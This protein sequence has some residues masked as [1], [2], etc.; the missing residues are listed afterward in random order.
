MAGQGKN[1]AWTG[2]GDGHRKGGGRFGYGGH[3]PFQ[4]V[5]DKEGFVQREIRYAYDL[6]L[7]KP[8]D[9]IFLIPLRLDDCPVPRKL[10]TIHW[11]D[12]FGTQRQDAYADL[13]EALQLRYDQKLKL[14]EQAEEH[15]RLEK[16]ARREAEELA[17]RLAVEKSAHKRVEQE[18]HAKEE[19]KYSPPAL[20]KRTSI[21]EL[22]PASFRRINLY[23]V[24]IGCVFFMFLCIIFGFNYLGKILSAGDTLG[25]AP[26]ATQTQKIN[27]PVTAD[28]NIVSNFL[29]ATKTAIVIPSP[30][31][32]TGSTMI[33][34]KDGMTMVYVPAGEFTMGDD[35][36]WDEKPAHTVYLDAFWIDQTEVTNK[37]Y[38]KCVDAGKC[39]PPISTHTPTDYFNN[40]RYVNH[41][42]VY[43]DWDMAKTYC[44]W[45]GR[46]LPTEPQWEKAAR[47]TD[48][49][50]YPWGDDLPNKNLLN[51]DH[52]VG[53]TTEVGNYQ[54]GKSYYG[55]YD[56]AGNVSEWTADWY[57]VYPG[58]DPNS[59]I[60]G[61]GQTRR[62]LRGGS[63]FDI[64]IETTDRSSDEPTSSNFDIGFRCARSE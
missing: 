41:P 11:V 35:N 59:S 20:A 18:A 25:Q 52:N 12:Y 2:L 45:A 53:G 50:T 22:L 55:A 62:V 63:G 39:S 26:Y 9:T 48:G 32:G 36:G 34:E 4:S 33:S 38:A 29:V 54:S 57:D 27:L 15:E 6:A 61:F 43:V 10:R 5:G 19:Q 7:E 3:L 16:H 31:L 44:E 17:R 58:G 8:E 1:P 51:Y 40:A 24:F 28:T 47:G 37:M 64:F 46:E 13:L 23:Y 21:L 42:V 30:T 14:E 60:Y 56:M 49:R